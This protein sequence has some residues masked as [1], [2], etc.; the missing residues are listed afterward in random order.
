MKY[1]DDNI[2]M[3]INNFKNIGNDMNDNIEYLI[4]GFKSKNFLIDEINEIEDMKI[5]LKLRLKN[6]IIG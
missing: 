3:R 4:E 5:D 6:Y 1:D 2:K